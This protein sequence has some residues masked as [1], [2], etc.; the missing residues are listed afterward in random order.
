MAH[1]TEPLFMRLFAVTIA[2]SV[3]YLFTSFTHVLNEIFALTVF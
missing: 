1:D 3:D 2:S